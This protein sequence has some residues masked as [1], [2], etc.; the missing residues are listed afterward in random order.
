MYVCSLQ[1]VYVCYKLSI[2]QCY[3]YIITGANP[4]SEINS[5]MKCKSD[6]EK[7]PS[8]HEYL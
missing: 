7:K 8:L 1:I 2:I 5:T 3:Y 6:I 4:T